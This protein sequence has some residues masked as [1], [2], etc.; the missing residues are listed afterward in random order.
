M[1]TFLALCLLSRVAYT[2]N[3][4]LVG[5]LARK[6]DGME[7]AAFRGVS[8]G[9]SMA[10]L[11]FWVAPSAWDALGA[12]S[13]ELLVLISVTAVAN[14]LQLEAARHLPFGLRAALLVT[15]VAIGGLALGAW[16]FGERF[17]PAELG[18]CAVIVTSAVLGSLGDHSTD[19]FT[20]NVPKGAVLTL[21]SSALL[22]VAA[23]SFTRLA[24][25]THPMLVAWA[26]ELGAGALLIPPL[27]WRR[28]RGFEP[29]VLR[30]FLRTG[31]CSL[32]T[33]VGTG[34][35]AVA[36]TLGSLGVW[37]AVAGTQA[38]LS[39]GLGAVRHRERIGARRWSYFVLGAAGIAGLAL[40]QTAK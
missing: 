17:S 16:F 36:L 31:L 38:L 12:R 3:D 15:G 18:W 22:C 30:R 7:I 25:S 11:L 37:S 2:F 28:R 23:L 27:L 39:A 19:G 32:P 35:T 13:G 1:L 9:I 26:W 40:A 10:P 29:L 14:V 8:L 21:A 4:V 6:H 24:R 34:A 20:A 33:V 5:E